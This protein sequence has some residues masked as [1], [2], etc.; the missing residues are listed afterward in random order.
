MMSKQTKK[1]KQINTQTHVPQSDTTDSILV[2]GKA[3]DLQNDSLLVQLLCRVLDAL[4]LELDGP[5]CLAHL[6]L[7]LT[8]EWWC[9][10]RAEKSTYIH[11]H[12]SNVNQIQNTHHNVEIFLRGGGG[13]GGGNIFTYSI[14]NTV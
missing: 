13:G 9:R 1:N 14:L 10:R 8:A 6:A 3:L 5:C 2:V 11:T 7:A 12:H 4:L